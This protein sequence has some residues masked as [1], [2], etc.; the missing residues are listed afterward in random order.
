LFEPYNKILK[1]GEEAKKIEGGRF[2]NKHKGRKLVGHI[3]PVYP[4]GWFKLLDSQDLA[5]GQSTYVE[6]LGNHFA[7]FR[8][9][10]GKVH[11]VDAYCP[12]LGANLG[13]GGTVHGNCIQC[14]FHGWSFNGTDG[15]CVSTP[16]SDKIPKTAYVKS[17][18]S[19]EI[20]GVILV[21]FDA[22][23][24]QAS[25]EPPKIEGIGSGSWRFHGRIEHRIHVH[26]QEIPENGADTAHLN[27]LHIP[28]V[29]G[30]DSIVR[31]HWDATWEADEKETHK[32]NIVVKEQMLFCGRYVP[33]SYSEAKINQYG[34]GLVYIHMYTPL[35]EMW[36]LE[37]VTP[38]GP[39]HQKVDHTI[40]APPWIPRFLVKFALWNFISQFGRDVPIWDTKTFTHNPMVLKGD[41]PLLQYRRWFSRFYSENSPTLE[42]LEKKKVL[43]W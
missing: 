42:S 43:D 21:H 9:E 30:S 20:N 23:G 26:I 24:R 25:W 11:I 19:L 2:K 35:G 33:F 4:N 37:A 16:Y 8:G 12:H 40:W 36:I 15:S 13:I 6:A 5:V 29:M 1:F 22:E 3:P 32:S 14:P 39:L 31:H 17:W 38:V 27:V 7:L 28:T 41:G 18:K 10:D 34:P